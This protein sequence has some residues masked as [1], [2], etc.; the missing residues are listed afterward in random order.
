MCISDEPQ[1]TRFISE[2]LKTTIKV[3]CIVVVFSMA[4][5]YIESAVVVYL[6]E[7]FHPDG[8]SFPVT[9]F[10]LSPIGRRL[11]LTEIGREAA[12]L[13]LIL[14][15]SW[16]FGKNRR[17][18]FA[19]FM[20]IFAV[21]DIFYYVWLKVLLGWPASVMDWDILFLIPLTWASAVLYPVLV[22]VALLVFAAVI[23]YRD[24]H[25]KTIKVTLTD[26]LAF[27]LAGIVIVVS[28]CTPGPHVT[29][30]DY[31]SYFYWPLFAAGLALAVG[32]F[33]K[34]LVKSESRQ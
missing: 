24:A 12:T 34:S 27:I 18:R 13:V 31:K 25:G 19:Y 28:F 33:I 3:F 21:W 1:T 10:D 29:E 30:P 9:V 11:L 8:F 4:F 7:I 6:R 16:L 5:A 20:I 32:M 26:W 14:T 17:Q 23:L 15:S 2:S 22:S